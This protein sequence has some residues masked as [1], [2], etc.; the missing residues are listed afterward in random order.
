MACCVG[1]GI[2]VAVRTTGTGVGSIALGCTG[3]SRHLGD[4]AVAQSRRLCGKGK[5]TVGG[6]LPLIAVSTRCG[7]GG[8][9]GDGLGVIRSIQLLQ[10]HCSSAGAL[11]TGSRQGT[12]CRGGGIL[13][14]LVAVA[15]ALVL[16]VAAGTGSLMVG[17]VCLGIGVSMGRC[18]K[19]G[20][21]DCIPGNIGQ[22][23]IPALKAV[24]V[25]AVIGSCRGRSGIDGSFPLV[26][27]LCPQSSSV[28]VAKFHLI[29]GRRQAA[30]LP[31]VDVVYIDGSGFP[32]G[33]GNVLENQTEGVQPFSRNI[34]RAVLQ[35]N[36]KD[37]IFPVGHFSGGQA[38]A[39]VPCP[40]YGIIKG[41]EEIQR[42][43][44]PRHCRT[45]GHGKPD[46][47]NVLVAGSVM[48]DG[49]GKVPGLIRS[50]NV[51]RMSGIHIVI[52]GGGYLHG[53]GRGAEGGSRTFLAVVAP[54]SCII[55]LKAVGF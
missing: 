40:I 32:G 50:L 9:L 25:A 18:R 39:Y 27:G 49:L 34:G 48:Q 17:S 30:F 10:G 14:R 16:A 11:G 5:G 55:I 19:L 23:L 29:P 37:M 24:M 46:L 15:V 47:Q 12:R 31:Y 1:V 33:A 38:P 54:G 28:P 21:N 22:G 13:G 8:G 51:G 26:K 43:R 35:G 2:L 3:G 20:S 7:T 6:G 53:Q 36:G 41:K 44:F 45:V 52:R 4:I 42:R